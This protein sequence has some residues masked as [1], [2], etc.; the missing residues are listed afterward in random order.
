MGGIRGFFEA[1][2]ESGKK[3]VLVFFVSMI[4]LIGIYLFTM[5]QL[6]YEH[7]EIIDDDFSWVY[8][9][10][11]I[12]KEEDELQITGWAFALDEDAKQE[13]F[14]IIL[15]DTKTGKGVHPKMIYELREDVNEYFLCE[16]DYTNSG[17]VA[18][19][20]TKYL[21]LENTVYEILLRPK[22][23]RKTF[24]TQVYYSDGEMLYVHPDKFAPLEVAGTDLEEI[25]GQGVLRVYQPNYGIYVYQYKGELYWIAEP[26]YGYDTYVQFQMK[27]TQVEKLPEDQL[28]NYNSFGWSSLRFMF[29]RKEILDWNTGKYR[30]ARYSLP[31]EYSL[32]HIRTGT[33]IDNWI[34]IWQSSF[35]PRYDFD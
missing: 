16:Y 29:W 4:V 30:V 11:N 8:Q 9:I 25:V 35:R 1:L 26:N 28:F 33:Y 17:F 21:Q 13:K 10:D 18:T 5:K 7:F 19:I 6:L 23:R 20:S 27:T 14:E 3:Q 15:Y 24:S 2:K 34:W 22:G 32:T 12:E 31:T